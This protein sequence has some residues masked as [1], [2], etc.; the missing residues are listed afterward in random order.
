MQIKQ[1]SKTREHKRQKKK[2]H[3]ACKVDAMT[4]SSSTSDE[5]FDAKLNHIYHT[6][7][8]QGCVNKMMITLTLEECLSL[9]L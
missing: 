4:S 5:E 1:D 3:S 2:A 6:A 9:V 8:S 7:R